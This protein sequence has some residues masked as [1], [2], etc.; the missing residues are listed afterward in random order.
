MAENLRGEIPFPQQPVT[1]RSRRNQL[2]RWWMRLPA[3][4]EIGLRVAE[5]VGVKISWQGSGGVAVDKGR[6][7]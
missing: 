2:Y 7:R 5:E 4:L 6:Q 3:P 1:R